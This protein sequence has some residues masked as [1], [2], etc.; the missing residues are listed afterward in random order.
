MRPVSAILNQPREPEV[1]Y[2]EEDDLRALV[3]GPRWVLLGTMKTDPMRKQLSVRLARRGVPRGRRYFR[4]QGYTKKGEFG[5]LEERLVGELT[6]N[7][8]EDKNST[9]MP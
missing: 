9:G 3:F 6:L 8:F 4:I 7:L 1:W 2:R 5:F